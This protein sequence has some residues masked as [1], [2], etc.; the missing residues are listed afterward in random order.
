MRWSMIE[1]R[2]ASLGL[3]WSFRS[4]LSVAFWCH[5]AAWS[6]TWVQEKEIYSRDNVVDHLGPRGA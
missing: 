3:S 6:W 4:G 2:M 5:K 1:V